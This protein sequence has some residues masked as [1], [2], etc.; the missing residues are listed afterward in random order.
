[1]ILQIFRRGTS[2]VTTLPF[3]ACTATWR[4]NRKT[5]E[6][7]RRSSWSTRTCVADGLCC[8]TSRYIDVL[9]I[10]QCRN[11]SIITFLT[12]LPLRDHFH[13]F[14]GQ[15]IMFQHYNVCSHVSYR[16]TCSRML[17]IHL[18]L[19]CPPP[20]SSL[21]QYIIVQHFFFVSYPDVSMPFFFCL[22]IVDIWH[23]LASS[24]VWPGFWHGPFWSLEHTTW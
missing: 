3:P 19:C 12:F 18:R 20:P 9:W 4:R 14:V 8:R 24:S 10:M 7:T 13:I 23:T 21:P 1:M 2:T 15:S 5:N 22:T 11:W 6:N 16:F 17:S